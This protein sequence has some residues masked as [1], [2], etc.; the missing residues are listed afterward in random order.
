MQNAFCISGFLG[1]RPAG[2]RQLNRLRREAHAGSLDAVPVGVTAAP[3]YFAA[4]L[5]AH[6]PSRAASIRYGEAVNLSGLPEHSGVHA[7]S[8][9]IPQRPHRL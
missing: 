9:Y 3:D 8:I 6:F 1:F 7:I 4:L 5:F 2:F